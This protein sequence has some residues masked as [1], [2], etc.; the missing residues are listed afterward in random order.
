MEQVNARSSNTVDAVYVISNN[1]RA[2]SY[3]ILTKRYRKSSRVR[4]THA[5][6]GHSAQPRAELRISARIDTSKRL[7]EFRSQAAA[8]DAPYLKVSRSLD[9]H[10]H[11]NMREAADR[12]RADIT[13]LVRRLVTSA[14]SETTI[15][16]LNTEDKD[17]FMEVL[18]TVVGFIFAIFSKL[19]NT[20][21]CKDTSVREDPY[22][23]GKAR[24]LKQKLYKS[25]LSIPASMF[26]VGT[27]LIDGEECKHGG[28]ADI[29]RA[30]Y[31]GRMVA[32]KCLRLSQATKNDPNVRTVS[33]HTYYTLFFGGGLIVSLL[34][35]GGSDG[36]GRPR[37]SKHLG[38]HR[39]G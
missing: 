23:F 16:G 30:T 25:C 22:I 28:F 18:S 14:A 38:V 9:I 4:G 8:Y 1:L 17:Q 37:A 2:S 15:L 24:K 27:Q 12:D 34:G 7:I 19:S 13:Q 32:V 26:I 21:Q 5:R 29:Y 10:S 20:L 31:G 36:M 6:L 3:L 33:I 11:P 39:S 35:T